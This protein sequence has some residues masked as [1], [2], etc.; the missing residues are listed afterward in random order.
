M[1]TV[2][3][4][5]SNRL[6]TGK[7]AF[8]PASNRHANCLPTVSDCLPTTFLPTPHT[9]QPVGSPALGPWGPRPAFHRRPKRRD[10]Q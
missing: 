8:Q 6:P 5:P 9:P 2:T 10:C 7:L 4:Y 1:K 3:R